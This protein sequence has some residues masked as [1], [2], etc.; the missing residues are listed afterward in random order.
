MHQ[1]VGAAYCNTPLCPFAC[2]LCGQ[3]VPTKCRHAVMR[4]TKPAKKPVP[5]EPHEAG[6]ALPKTQR[7]L[8][9]CGNQPTIRGKLCQLETAIYGLQ[10]SALGVFGAAHAEVRCGAGAYGC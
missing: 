2:S 9:V 7:E 3:A 6:L 8:T 5:I 4:D 10:N 1:T